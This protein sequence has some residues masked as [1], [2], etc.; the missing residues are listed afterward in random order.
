MA[1]FRASAE[2]MTNGTTTARLNI[3]ILSL[4][5]KWTRKVWSPTATNCSGFSRLPADIWKVGKPPTDTARSNDHFTSWAV[6]GVPS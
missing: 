4:R 2:L 1:F 3:S 6:T 5:T